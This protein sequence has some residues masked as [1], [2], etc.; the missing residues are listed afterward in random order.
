MTEEMVRKFTGYESLEE[1]L[2]GY[3]ITGDKLASLKVP[4]S[5]ITAYDDPII[6]VSGLERLPKLPTLTVTVTRHGG[7][8]GFFD[9][10]AGPTWLES[11][12]LADLTGGMSAHC[13]A[14]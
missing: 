8:C 4:A 11:R 2:N 6:P 14:E 7:H 5:V 3:S 9:R 12:I 10:L 1:Y 13:Q